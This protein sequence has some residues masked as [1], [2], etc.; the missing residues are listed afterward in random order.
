MTSYRVRNGVV[1]RGQ[2]DYTGRGH[3]DPATKEKGEVFFF[4][5]LAKSR[6]G[7]AQA[8][9][10]HIAKEIGQ[11]KDRERRQETK[12]KVKD[13]RKLTSK[14]T[15]G[16]RQNLGQI[17]MEQHL[18]QNIPTDFKY[19]RNILINIINFKYLIVY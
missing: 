14:D 5:D 19:L 1:H 16:I 7:S 15:L 11:A 12:K 8:A 17:L 2:I 10:G 6:P 3:L 4:R 13:D 9:I 18:H